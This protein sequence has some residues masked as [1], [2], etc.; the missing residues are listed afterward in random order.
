MDLPTWAIDKGTK[1]IDDSLAGFDFS[2]FTVHD[3]FTLIMEGAYAYVIVKFLLPV[4]I[5]FSLVLMPWFARWFVLPF[6]R[7][8]KKR[9]PHPKPADPAPGVKKITKPRL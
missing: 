6:T 4:R 1:I 9:T 3:K 5:M 2:S 7:L 8:F